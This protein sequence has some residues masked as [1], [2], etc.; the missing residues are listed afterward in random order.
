VAC[1]STINGTSTRQSTLT[2]LCLCCR[3]SPAPRFFA[4][5]P[6]CLVYRSPDEFSRCLS[7]AMTTE[8]TPLSPDQLQALTWEAATERFL[9]VGWRGAVNAVCMCG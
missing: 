5:F 6:N 4:Q 2:Q 1:T 9:Q 7:H 8:P 3:P